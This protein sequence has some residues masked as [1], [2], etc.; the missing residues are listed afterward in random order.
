VGKKEERCTHSERRRW[1]RR[2][3]EEEEEE[4]G[5]GEGEGVDF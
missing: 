3:E 1:G 5:E 4:E 2:K